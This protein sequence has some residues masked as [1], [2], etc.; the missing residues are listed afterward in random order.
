MDLRKLLKDISNDIA[1]NFENFKDV[2]E[3]ILGQIKTR[4]R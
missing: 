4:K 3:Y 2:L 1:D